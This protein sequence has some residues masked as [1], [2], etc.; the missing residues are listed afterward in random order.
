MI[1]TSA[2]ELRATDDSPLG[3]L[4]ADAM[5]AAFAEAARLESDVFVGQVKGAGT[6]VLSSEVAAS[7]E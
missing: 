7:S 2:Q 6:V 5:R 4:V 1:A 3:D